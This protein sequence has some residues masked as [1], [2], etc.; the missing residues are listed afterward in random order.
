MQVQRTFKKREGVGGIVQGDK[1]GASQVAPLSP[2]TKESTFRIAKRCFANAQHDKIPIVI[3]SKAK[4][5]TV[6]KARI[7][8]ILCLLI[9]TL[10]LLARNDPPPCPLRKGGGRIPQ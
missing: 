6:C 10:A 8:R 1:G 9:A 2:L 5:S 7:M 3:A 4:Q